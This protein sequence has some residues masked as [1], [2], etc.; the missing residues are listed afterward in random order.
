MRKL[1][2]VLAAATLFAALPFA[3]AQSAPADS[4]Q[5][6]QAL[7]SAVG[8]DKKGYVGNMLQLTDAEAKK[9]WPVYEAYQRTLASSDRRRARAYEDLIATDRP[10]S[11]AYAKKLSEEMLLADEAELKARRTMHSGAMR[12]LPDKKAAQY[13]QLEARLRA[14]KQY[15]MAAAM[16]AIK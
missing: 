2:L 15:D 3:H 12:A 4:V 11:D 1:T 9:F 14:A 13:L 5:G 6:M 10:I 8:Q 16:P 7:R